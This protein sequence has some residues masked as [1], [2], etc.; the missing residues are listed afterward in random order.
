LYKE[1]KKGYTLN[2]HAKYAKIYKGRLKSGLAK[3]FKTAI[4]PETRKSLLITVVG[5]TGACIVG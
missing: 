2:P 1:E 4:K 3:P 5:P